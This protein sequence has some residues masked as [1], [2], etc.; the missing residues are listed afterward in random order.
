MEEKRKEVRKENKEESKEER[1]ETVTRERA[2][3]S[4]WAFHLGTYG[5]AGAKRR[6][7]E[8]KSVT[9]PLPCTAPRSLGIIMTYLLLTYLPTDLPT[10]LGTYLSPTYLF[11]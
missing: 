1:R 10:Y 9:I 3:G 5:R 7:P 6:R 2:R 8:G 11:M 4:R